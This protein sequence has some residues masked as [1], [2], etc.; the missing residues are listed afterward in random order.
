MRAAAPPTHAAPDTAPPSHGHRPE[1]A[2]APE[3]GELLAGTGRLLRL[4]LR[5]D[6]LRITLWALAFLLL[7]AGSVL[8]LEETYTTPESLQARAML[9]GNPAAIMMTG[10]AFSLDNYTFGAMLASELSLWV[11]LPAAIMSVLLAVRHT[12]ADEESG[13]L[14]MLRALPVGRFAAP[15]AALVTVAVANLAVG[16]AVTTAL[17]VTDQDVPGSFALGAATALTGLVFGGVA[18]VTAQLTEHSR[19]ASGAALGVIGAAFLVRGVG[20]V[21]NHQGSWLSWFSP[22]AWA[23]QTKLF[24]DLRWWPLGVPAVVAVLLLVLATDLARRRDLGAGLRAPRPGPAAAASRLLSPVG[25][26]RRLTSGTF[27]A[28]TIGLFLFAVAF[29]SL[30]TEL[31]GMI[32]DTPALEQWMT[33]DLD[34][35]TRSFAAVMLSFLMVAPMALVVAGILQLRGEEQ[36]GRVEG[37]VVS[38]SSRTGLFAGWLTAVTLQSVLVLV[39]LGVGVGAGV[40]GASGEVGWVGELTLASLAYVPSM[41]LAGAIAVALYG[42]VPRLAGLAWVPVVWASIVAF[43]G[44]LLDLPQWARNL[45]PLA[46]TPMV[47]QADAEVTPLVVMTAIAVVLGVVGLA[48]MRR[49]DITSN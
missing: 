24:V 30:A 6:R 18:A 45:S 32:E 37:M 48:G 4:F 35:L 40:A 38:G 5:L 8:S 21:I 15:T 10:P 33:F 12:R 17:L 19:A 25:L 7:V 27:V 3:R 26:A 14:E 49:R 23:Q 16:A 11:F 39:V 42:L 44:E 13:R 28:W 22:F 2:L 43:L 29:G 36:A 9:M 20:D 1:H 46:H 31:E 34:D 47:P 41:L